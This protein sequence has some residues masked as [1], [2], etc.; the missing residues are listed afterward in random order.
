MQR[1]YLPLTLKDLVYVVILTAVFTFFSF[2]LYVR[3]EPTQIEGIYVF[4]YGLPIPWLRTEAH[5]SIWFVSE[6]QIL[7]AALV[8][9]IILYFLLSLTLVLTISWLATKFR[10]AEKH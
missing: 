8:S 5:V 4:L 3:V 10:K 9:D 7:W 1:L 2:I 6:S